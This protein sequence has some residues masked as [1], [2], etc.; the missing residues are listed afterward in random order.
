MLERKDLHIIAEAGTNNNGELGKAKN[1]ADIALRAK[2]DSVKFQIINTWG[3]YLPGEY[4]YGKYDI[5]DVIRIRE[6]GQMTDA[7]Y[8]ELAAH[9]RDIGIPFT[10]SVFDVKGL[11]LLME[12][13]PPY[14]KFASCDINHIQLLREAATRRTRLVLSTGMSTF[15]DVEITMNELAR[16]NFSDVVLLHCVSAYPASLSQANLN[17]IGTLRKHFNVDVG[18]SDHT[19]TSIAACMALQQGATW[20]EK[21]F[22]E[23]NTQVG[24]DHAYAMEPDQLAAYVKDI[25]SARLAL[26]SE[27]KE[28]SKAELT[29]RK[30]ARRSLYAARALS[31]GETIQE[32]DVLIVRPEGKIQ[33]NEIDRVVGCRLTRDMEQYENFDWDDLQN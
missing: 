9:C 7:E 18:F 26:Q 2:A 1:L 22:T 23:D 8:R 11:D 12:F 31:A 3:L 24:L 15:E 4:E 17:Y 10:A 6:Q 21:H 28:L 19:G 5:K 13:E 16:L 33:A 29:T 27:N 32:S 20:F 30:R 14:I 25:D